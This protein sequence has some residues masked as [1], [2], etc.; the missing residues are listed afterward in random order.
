MKTHKYTLERHTHGWIIKPPQFES[1]I[2][3]DALNEVMPLFGKNAV[4]HSGIANTKGGLF[5]IGEPKEL[6]TWAEQIESELAASNISKELQWLRGAKV[7][8]SSLTIFS[9]LADQQFQSEARHYYR[10]TFEPHLP[11]DSA[12]FGR[13][14]YLVKFMGWRERLREVTAKFPEWAHIVSVWDELS[15]LY[16]ASK[17]QDVRALMKQK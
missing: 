15:E 13:C 14:L 7:G 2:P 10:D 11:A 12:D 6:N 5:A 16:K 1:G 4:M 9:A 8:L 17:F 3:M